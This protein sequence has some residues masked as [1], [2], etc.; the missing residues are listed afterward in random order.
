MEINS[1]EQLLTAIKLLIKQMDR[2][3]RKQFL[4]WIKRTK[5]E[6]DFNY[7]MGFK[8]EVPQTKET[9]NEPVTEAATAPVIS[10]PVTELILPP[11]SKEASPADGR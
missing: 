10:V 1:P 11:G 7:P 4:E 9:P 5:N 6:Y 8:L 3:Q 2:P